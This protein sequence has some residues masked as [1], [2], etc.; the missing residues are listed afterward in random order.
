[1]TKIKNRRFALMNTL[2]FNLKQ[3]VDTSRKNPALSRSTIQGFTKIQ[4]HHYILDEILIIHWPYVF[5][6]RSSF[7]SLAD[8]NIVEIIDS[9]ATLINFSSVGKTLENSSDAQERHR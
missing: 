5:S 7:V 4:W 2:I 6:H 3:R 9:P 1:M 8:V